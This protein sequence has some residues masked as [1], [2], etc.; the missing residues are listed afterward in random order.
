MQ[1]EAYYNRGRLYAK[2]KQVDRAL[3]DF[4]KAISLKPSAIFQAEKRATL[5]ADNQYE[6]ARKAYSAALMINPSDPT[7][8]NNLAWLQSTCPDVLRFACWSSRR[9]FSESTGRKQ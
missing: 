3:K 8:L 6:D 9:F 7:T 5:H 1:A 4:D 2:A